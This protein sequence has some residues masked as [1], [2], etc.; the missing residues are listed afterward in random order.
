MFRLK[1]ALMTASLL[2]SLFGFACGPA[3][4]GTCQ[5]D[6]G[7]TCPS[8]MPVEGYCEC[9]VHGTNVGGTVVSP[10]FPAHSTAGSFVPGAA[11]GS[12]GHNEP[13]HHRRHMPPAPGAEPSS[14][15][16]MPPPPPPGTAPQYSP[17][18]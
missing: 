6:S 13:V 14:G 2:G 8:Q 10:A 15:P 11:S 3:F 4:A 7:L 5:T 12:P 9:N 16:G 17:P 1:S 18:Q